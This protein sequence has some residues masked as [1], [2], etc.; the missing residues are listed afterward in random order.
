MMRMPSKKEIELH[1]RI[2]PW[3]IPGEVEGE[4]AKLKPDAPEDIKRAYKE[5]LN[6]N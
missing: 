2:A 1:E 6:T 4:P 5:W 3:L